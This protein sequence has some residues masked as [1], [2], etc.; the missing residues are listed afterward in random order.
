MSGDCGNR[1]S[2]EERL[3]SLLY[4]DGDPAELAEIRAHLAM[5]AS[6]REELEKLTATRELLSAWPDVVNAPRLVYVNEPAPAAGRMGREAG[7]RRWAGFRS[8]VPSL[9]TAAALL[10]LL[11]LSAPFLR[12]QVGQD[13]RVHV[14]LGAS[15]AA[16]ANGSALVT[17]GDLDQGLAQTAQYLEALMRAGRQED[18]QAVLGAVDQAL[19]AQ[20]ASS[21]EQVTTAINSAFDELDRRRR[22]DLGV[23]LSSMSDLQAMTRSELQQMNAVLASLTSPPSRDQE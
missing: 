7:R 9:A 15:S 12:V 18:R 19:Q 10:L 11:G 5:C 6:C 14:G 16:P 17:R 4:E 3:V 1:E 20:S 8:L 13:G 23:M 22:T 2:R 21:Q